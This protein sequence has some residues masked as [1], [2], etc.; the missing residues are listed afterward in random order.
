[1]KTK[2]KHFLNLATLCLALLSTTL[3]TTQPVKAEF[4]TTYQQNGENSLT[5]ASNEGG[6]GD[7]DLRKRY[8]TERGLTEGE[9][10]GDEYLQGGADGYVD[11]Y[12]RG[13]EIGAPR[14]PEDK[15]YKG[16]KE[17]NYKTGYNDGYGSGYLYGWEENH[18]IQSFLSYI[19]GVI[20]EF[21]FPSAS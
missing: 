16:D 13:S 7:A 4:V 17:G 12:K 1:M 5:V 9:L 19:W 21:F 15:P 8:L 6:E 11:G 10:T 2:S 20:T 14:N 3:L 18:P